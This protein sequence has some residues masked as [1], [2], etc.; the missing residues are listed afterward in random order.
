AN[1]QAPPLP[2]AG[3]KWL[4]PRPVHCWPRLVN[5]LVAGFVVGLLLTLTGWGGHRA[6]AQPERG[7]D[8]GV[9]ITQ[10]ELAADAGRDIAA[11]RELVLNEQWPQALALLAPLVSDGGTR[12]VEWDPQR[13]MGARAAANLLLSAFPRVQL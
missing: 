4:F 9:A 12:L 2:R 8:P 5:R 7:D 13:Q 1:W 3:L 6:W 10:F 11:A